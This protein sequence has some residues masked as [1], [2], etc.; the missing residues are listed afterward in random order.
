MDHGNLYLPQEHLAATPI[1]GSQKKRLFGLSIS[2]HSFIRDRVKKSVRDLTADTGT[3]G[4]LQ[5]LLAC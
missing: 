3:Y 5:T 4:V 1:F 2:H